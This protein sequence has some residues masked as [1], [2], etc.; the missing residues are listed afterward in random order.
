[1]F[2]HALIAHLVSAKIHQTGKAPRKRVQLQQMYQGARGR[3]APKHTQTA[4]RAQ[5]SV[6][7][8]CRVWCGA[9]MLVDA[10]LAVRAQ[11]EC[12]SGAAKDRH[13]GPISGVAQYGTV[14]DARDESRG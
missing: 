2:K 8:A 10:A 7:G 13:A 4:A 11:D 9:C 6:Q 1:M 14:H 12:E 3:Q 5:L